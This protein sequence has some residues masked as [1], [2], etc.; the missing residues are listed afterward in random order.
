MLLVVFGALFTAR[1]NDEYRTITPE[2][3]KEQMPQQTQLFQP[4]IEN[5]PPNSYNQYNQYSNTAPSESHAHSHPHTQRNEDHYESPS[6][7]P[8]APPP[9]SNYGYYV[10]HAGPRDAESRDAGH[11]MASVYMPMPMYHEYDPER[12]GMCLSLTTASNSFAFT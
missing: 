9:Q 1:A 8:P 2:M 12:I 6:P 5:A 11:S 7:S 10:R 3:L 4:N